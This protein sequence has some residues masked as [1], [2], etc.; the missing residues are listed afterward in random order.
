MH[1]S[2]YGLVKDHRRKE[3]R[4]NNSM[5]GI[6]IND[7]YY[8]FTEL[9]LSREK[10][11]ET[12]RTAS[13]NAYVGKRVGII[14]TG[15]GKAMLVGFVTIGT[16]V[17]YKTQTEFRKDDEKHHVYEGSMYDID[18][19]GKWGYPLINPVGIIPQQVHSKGIIARKI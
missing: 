1:A 14:R 6:N 13:L 2:N 16:P 3:E 15:K 18:E 19:R 17:F 5:M 9:I 11:I 12:R 10:T 8:P 7:K 4:K